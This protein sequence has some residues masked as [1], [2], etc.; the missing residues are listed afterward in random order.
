MK[1]SIGKILL[2]LAIVALAASAAAG[3]IA[4]REKAARG[5]PEIA[6]LTF[7]HYGKS[8]GQREATDTITDY[9]YNGV[10]WPDAA[11]VIR[12]TIDP[13]NKWGLQS[14]DIKTA[15]DSAAA[16]WHDADNKVTFVDDGI[17]AATA[18]PGAAPDGR[19]T[20]SFRSISSKFPN[21]IAVTYSWYYV[22]T[23]RVFEVDTI[24]NDD[25]PWS[26][27]PYGASFTGSYDVQ[28]IATHEIGH[29]LV[30][31]DL[32]KPRD[33]ELTMYGYGAMGE[34]KKDTLGVGDILGINRIY[35]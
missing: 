13:T 20:V 2:L 10:R 34:T 29:W 6:K 21:A 26:V 27:N 1:R 30:L 19:N 22:N 23:K 5:G 3:I 17:A 7:I 25:L 32:Y 31:G 18:D 28:N 8:G 4:A 9:K 15:V 35:P 24:F 12:F 11:P 16:A 14:F 33:A